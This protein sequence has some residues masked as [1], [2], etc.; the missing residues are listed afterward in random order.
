MNCEDDMGP[1]RCRRMATLVWLLVA[2]LTGLW[3]GTEA[4][5]K[6]CGDDVDGQD[7]PCACGDTVVGN[8]VLTDDP[9]ASASCPGDGLIIRAGTSGGSTVDLAAK[10]IRGSGRGAGLWI[11]DAGGGGVRLV[12]TGGTATIEKF[13]DGV[14]AQGAASVSAIE[15]LSIRDSGRDG[16]RLYDV[17]GVAVRDIEVVRSGRDGVWVNGRRYSIVASRAADSGRH[18][19]NLM[20]TEGSIGAAGA[21]NV[22]EG[23]G[24]AGF[25]LM[26]MD[27][28]ITECI[29]SGAA[30]DG[31]KFMGMRYELSGCLAEDNGGDG[32]AGRGGE[33][34]LKDN[35]ANHNENDGILVSGGALQ[36][37]GGNVGL[38]NRGRLKR[39]AVVQCEIGGVPCVP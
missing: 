2:L 22:V 23:S 20:G 18:G 29:V 36:D 17:E 38:E 21:G 39:R 35:R 13:Y 28:R 1:R 32:I 14:V 9:V 4:R 16:M 10:S 7:V 11:V 19:L 34:V 30:G 33:I 25:V 24:A 27:H 3:G 6:L 5:A 8:L 12:S 31:I 26:G 15:G 37:G